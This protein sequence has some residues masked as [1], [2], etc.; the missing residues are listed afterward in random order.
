[1]AKDTSVRAELTQSKV[2]QLRFEKRV[3]GVNDNGSLQFGESKS[4]DELPVVKDWVLR[5][6]KLLGFTV[7]V[8][9]SKSVYMVQRKMAL[10]EGPMGILKSAPVRRIIGSTSDIKLEDARK[11]AQL[12]LGW[13]ANGVDPYHRLQKAARV[14]ASEQAADRDTFGLFYAAYAD[15]EKG[16]KKSTT[17]DRKKVTKWMQGSP[18]WKVA[19]HLLSEADVEQSLDPLFQS[20]LGVAD[21][22]AWG[23]EKP[24]LATAMKIFRYT[25]AAYSTYK[26]PGGSIRNH[27][28]FANV[29]RD[30]AWPALDAK[31]GHLDA[32]DIKDR[33]WLRML[34]RLQSHQDPVMCVFADFLLCALI[35]GGRRREIQL[36]EWDHIDLEQGCAQF[37]KENTK[38]GK[39]HW[40]PITPWAREILEER[41]DKNKNWGRDDKWVFPSRRHGKSIADHRAALLELKKETGVWLTAHDLRRTVATATAAMTGGNAMLVAMTLGHSGGDMALQLRYIRNKVKLLRPYFEARERQLRETA[42]L[43]P[44]E[45]EATPIDTMI[46]FLQSAKADPGE[47]GAIEKKIEAMLIMLA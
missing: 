47:R 39:A 35:W 44:Y 25:A 45:Q 18:M 24:G 22:P 23:P 6:S 32:T 30:C 41:K 2:D 20:A 7:R 31:E 1:M 19:M 5:D 43:E 12:W 28:L 9:P 21:K 10:R 42:G 15:S 29:K 40:F 17:D 33:G 16:V 4:G 11:T 34:V 13:M 36:L 38:S 8:H 37:I 14:Q 3:V 46:E 26:G 27:S